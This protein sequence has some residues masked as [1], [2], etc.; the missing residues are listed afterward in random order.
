[1]TEYEQKRQEAESELCRN[2]NITPSIK[3]PV[4]DG[5]IILI[6]GAYLLGEYKKENKYEF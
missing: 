1:M 4:H 3:K 5:K 2:F 6:A